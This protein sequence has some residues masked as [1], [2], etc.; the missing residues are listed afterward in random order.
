[1]TAPGHSRTPSVELALKRLRENPP[2]LHRPIDYFED[3]PGGEDG[4]VSDWGIQSSFLELLDEFVAPGSLTL[5]TG[6]GLSTVCFAIIGSEH[7][8]ISPLAKEHIRVRKYCDENQISTE[9]LRFIP[10]RSDA[11]LPALDIGKRRLDFALIDGSHAFPA[12]IVDYFYVNAHLKVGGSLA[13][14]DLCISCVGILHKFLLT[15]PAYQMV[16]IDGLKTGI[17]KKVAETVYPRDFL[18][19]RFN[20]TFPDYSYLPLQTRVREEL[21]RAPSNLRKCL[22]KV[23]GLRS[24]HRLLKTSRKR[25]L[26]AS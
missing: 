6:C 13:V 16:K 21:R 7:I 19:Q 15:E 10:M 26:R 1:M 5:E 11:A 18:D 22:A 14:D 25:I 23:P 3:G 20:S 24:A 17:Y 4:L 9:Q 2:K 8:C 12:P